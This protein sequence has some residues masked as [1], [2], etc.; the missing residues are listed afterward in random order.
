MNTS[1]VNLT[2]EMLSRG[3]RVD[4]GEWIEGYYYCLSDKLNPFIMLPNRHGE[5]YEVIPETVGKFT[6]LS[7]TH[8]KKIFKG[9]IVKNRYGFIQVVTFEYGSVYFV[10]T[11]DYAFGERQGENFFAPEKTFINDEELILA[12]EIIGNIYDNPEFIDPETAY[13]KIEEIRKHTE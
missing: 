8:R 2:N 9:D 10:Q 12:D 7:D 6:T 1:F 3:K 13:E 4:N 5:S 11:L